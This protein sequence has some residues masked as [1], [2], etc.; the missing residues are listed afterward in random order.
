[1][2]QISEG[3][4]QGRPELR[5]GDKIFAVNNRLS[6]F[7][8]INNLLKSEADSGLSELEIV[9]GCALGIEARDE[10]FEMDLP[11]AVMEEIVITILAAMQ[12][13]SVEEAKRRFRGTAL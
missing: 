10:I 2:Y 1:M 9:I 13:L 12:D 11:Y 4:L 6:V 5:I 3:K 8:Q 7:R